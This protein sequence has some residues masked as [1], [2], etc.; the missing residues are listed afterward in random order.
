MLNRNLSLLLI[1]QLTLFTSLFSQSTTQDEHIRSNLYLVNADNSTTL[2]DGDYTAYADSYSNEIDGMDAMKLTNFTENLG[3]S[4]GN[5]I[6]AIERRQTIGLTDTIFYDMW[7]MRRRTYQLQFITVNLNHPGLSGF[8]EDKYLNTRT[9]VDLNG[10]TTS[11]FTITT[12]A[13]SGVPDRF[14]LVF[15]SAAKFGALPIT[16]ASVRAYQQNNNI[17]LDWKVENEFNIKQYEIQK[18]INGK[19]FMNTSTV[20]AKRNNSNSVSYQWVDVNPAAGNNFYRI[21]SVS[22]DGAVLYSNIMKVSMGSATRDIVIYPNPVVNGIVNLQLINQPKGKYAVRIINN[23]GQLMQATELHHEQGSASQTIL[24]DP[25][26]V[27]GTY[28]IEIT[29]PDNTRLTRKISLQ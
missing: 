27:K 21:R 14:R 13:A 18:S 22:L 7:Q 3:M 19:D 29:R 12:D 20:G 16:F 6:L 24:I 4:R 25:K 17:A 8:L 23:S 5:V 11:N 1:L 10:T 15:V 26:L 9:P 2:Y 28:N